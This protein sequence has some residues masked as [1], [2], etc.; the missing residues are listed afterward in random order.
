MEEIRKSPTFRFIS[1]CADILS[2]QDFMYY[3]VPC[4]CGKINKLIFLGRR[5]SKNRTYQRE[6]KIDIINGELVNG[7]IP[8]ISEFCREYNHIK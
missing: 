5:F 7:P 1:E 4:E 2:Y 3:K 6:E 8:Q